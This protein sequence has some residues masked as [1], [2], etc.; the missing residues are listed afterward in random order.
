[1]SAFFSNN[2]IRSLLVVG[3]LFFIYLV[4]FHP[5]IGSDDD[6]FFLYTLSGGF[7]HEPSAL[8]HYNFGWN[9]VLSWPLAQLFRINPHI[10]WYSLFLLL[11]QF[12]SCFFL[13]SV[14]LRLFPGKISIFL[15]FIFF[16]AIEPRLI[17]LLNYSNT[18]LIT[19]VSGS[20]ALLACHLEDKKL[21]GSYKLLSLFMIGVG[22]LL[23]LHMFGLICLP[24]LWTAYFLLSPKNFIRFFKQ[25]VLAGSVLLFL[26]ICQ[27]LLFRA[28]IPNWKNAERI[29]QY[30]FSISN[31][32]RKILN[33][34]TGTVR[35]KNSF[36]ER[37]FIYDTGFIKASDMET[38]VKKI[39]RNRFTLTTEDKAGLYW[40][41]LELR[42][43]LLFGLGFFLLLLFTIR[44][45]ILS[46]L[47]ICLAP[48]IV[49][50][51]LVLFFKINQTILVGLFAPLVFPSLW[52]AYH[53]G[54]NRKGV[55]LVQMVLLAAAAWALIKSVKI[56]GEN[57]KLIKET[58][59][60]LSE[61]KA[62][63]DKLFVN[64]DNLLQLKGYAIWNTPSF[65][66]AKNL[67][68]YFTVYTSL[69]EQALKDYRI[70]DLMAS[71][72]NNKNI[73]LVGLSLPDLLSYYQLKYQQYIRIIPTN[74]FHCIPAFH[75]ETV[76]RQSSIAH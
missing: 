16:I 76:N 44:Q 68:K 26:F 4:L 58:N 66:P 30:I 27:W 62:N 3:L 53:S 29:R 1:M 56:S 73:V 65:F 55:Q 70:H 72:P 51:T 69:Y 2:H 74:E 43:Y 52:M 25:I 75:I 18:A 19:V 34:D 5:I 59:C 67:I 31:H 71:I 60:I 47:L 8:L 36:I 13:C 37:G 40:L 32:P 63:R 6:F 45:Y 49:L 39:H 24:S 50:L 38:Y 46:W 28:E 61:I 12:S 42:T 20:T 9:P 14:F 41:F 64:S 15:F 33:T 10:N 23:R 17:L 11:L 57:Q 48:L 22:G 7:G 35:I 21:P 54:A